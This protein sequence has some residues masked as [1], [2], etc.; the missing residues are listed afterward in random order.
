MP[1][2]RIVPRE[3]LASDIVGTVP[4]KAETRTRCRKTDAFD[5]PALDKL[6]QSLL[7][8][9]RSKV[10]VVPPLRVPDQAPEAQPPERLRDAP[11]PPEQIQ[12]EVA[13]LG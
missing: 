2:A 10:V 6:A 13:L 8:P 9:R 5:A 7:D 1:R 4:G 3:L 11:R 12:E